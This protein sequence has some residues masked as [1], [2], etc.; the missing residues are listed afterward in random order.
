V[1]LS[2]VAP[3][4]DAVL[5]SHG[6]IAHLGAL[7]TAFA[8]CGLRRG[9][10]VCA[11][12]PVAK[13]GQ[14]TLYDLFAARHGDGEFDAFTLDDVD[15]AFASVQHLKYTQT[16]TLARTDGRTPVA[17]APFAA[18]HTLGGA[19]WRITAGAEEVVYAV[20]WNNRGERHLPPA[21]LGAFARPSLL[22][23]DA[24][25]ALAPPPPPRRDSE[26]ALCDACVA[27]LRADG[28]A[29][30]PCD[31][32]GRTLEVVLSLEAHWAANPGLGNYRVVLLTACAHSTME[33]AASQLE[34]MSEAV[35]RGFERNRDN[36]FALRH[37]TPVSSLD[38]L[39][40][41][42]PGPKV[43]LA[44][45]ASLAAGAA[46][47]LLA[48]WAPDPR[49]ML[50][51]TGPGQEATLARALA[52]AAPIPPPARPP[53]RLQLGR[54]VVLRD[55]ELAA[56]R[57]ARRAQAEA[58]AEAAAATQQA[59]AAQE[60]ASAAVQQ[61]G[62]AAE[63]ALPDGTV[64]MELTLAPE[65][66]AADVEAEAAAL[67]AGRQPC[68][69]DGFALPAGAVA[70]IFPFDERVV[71]V[72]EYGELVDARDFD[73]GA[74]AAAAAATAANEDDMAAERLA[75]PAPGGADGGEQP[76]KVV[77][78]EVSLQLACAIV[79]V[80]CSGRA[81]GRS[82][83]NTLAMME[84]RRVVLVHGSQEA[85]A[86]LAEHAASVLPGLAA[87]VV[88]PQLGECCDMSAAT[89]SL[90]VR[91]GDD[92]ADAATAALAPAGD[93]TYSVAWLDGVL[94]PS[95]AGSR[96]RLLCAPPPGEARRPH[97]P[98]FVGDFRFS[99]LLQACAAAGIPAE[100]SAGGVL[101][102]GR[103]VSVRKADG[104][105]GAEGE[106]LLEGALGDDFY[107]VRDVLSARYHVI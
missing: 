80:D 52:S 28:C 102:C 18:G 77:A 48:R 99:D 86:A 55:E 13:M 83:R 57:D 40:A 4:V 41:L 92:A 35:A 76:T 72:S 103:G 63:A 58:D 21:A 78:S 56:W 31:A 39:D 42:P 67:C 105:P 20:D 45:L 107:A 17:V 24:T 30:L 59:E 89:P 60:P 15:A 38:A 87:P 94:R 51:F 54:R 65:G 93:G 12:T 29:L 44:S 27:C 46:R 9:T 49:C 73:D 23:M 97:C 7:P 33:F 88:A 96:L 75:L 91:L 74:G 106:L 5:L 26:R 16:L 84:P 50:L 79:V 70:P 8:R 81:D 14:L 82:V 62:V 2:A 69:V 22:I 37:V 95:L 64:S 6:D 66:G 25:S 32:A 3:R 104:P 10:P 34:W 47:A 36:P 100:F 43:V 90:R 61:E 11:T 101:L 98:A 53:L 68:L 71:A 19:L 1:P 85:T